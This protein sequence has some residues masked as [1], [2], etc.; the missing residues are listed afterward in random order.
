[1]I[2]Q[3]EE[4]MK[5]IAAMHEN[6]HIVAVSMGSKWVVDLVIPNY[7]TIRMRSARKQSREFGNIASLIKACGG[8]ADKLVI[9]LN[10]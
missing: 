4:E 6:K 9:N 10:K 7:A 2:R 1:M 8:M 3:T 5:A